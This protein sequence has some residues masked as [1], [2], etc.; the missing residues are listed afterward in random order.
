MS[1]ML[2]MQVVADYVMAV[3]RS[4]G[5]LATA[6]SAAGRPGRQQQQPREKRPPKASAIAVQ[7]TARLY[8]Q[9]MSI[10]DIAS[11]QVTIFYNKKLTTKKI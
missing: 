10:P 8:N 3:D 5:A 9:G 4:H 11:S 1:A 6:P 2:H 7:Q